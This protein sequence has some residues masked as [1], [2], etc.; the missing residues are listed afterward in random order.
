[1]QFSLLF[2]QN[3]DYIDKNLDRKRLNSTA[4]ITKRAEEERGTNEPK[5]QCI[6][7][8]QGVYSH[9]EHYDKGKTAV[10]YQ[11]KRSRAL[12][13]NNIQKKVK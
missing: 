11:S 2:F 7:R 9:T 12:S 8:K 1:M 6:R 4:K 5:E 3:V 10:T 13:A